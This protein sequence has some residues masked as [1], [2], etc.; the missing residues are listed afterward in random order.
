MRKKTCFWVIVCTVVWLLGGVQTPDALAKDYPTKPIQL[1]YPWPAGSGGDIATRLLAEAA[2]KVLGQPVKVI[3]VPG[4]NGTIGAAQ[5]VKAKK[6]G[7]EL[8]S[9]PI[10]P[11]VTQTVFSKDLPYTTADLEPICQFTYLPLVLVA[12]AHTPYK[13]LDE[14]V[15]YAKS[16]PEKVLFVIPGVGSVPHLSMLS[17]ETGFGIKMKGVPYKGLAPGVTALVGGHV[18]LAPASLA[19]VQSF[20]KAGKLRILAIFARKRLD[21]APDIITVEERGLKTYPNVWTG[22]FGPKGLSPAVLKV[23]E[24][25]FAKAVAEKDFAD[26]MLKAKQPVVFLDSKAFRAKIAADLEYFKKFA[27]EKKD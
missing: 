5:V 8:G 18:D 2:S 4:G 9:L 20:H 6:D 11:A 17:L 1:V 25:S 16:N 26:S 21:L 3:N 19:E 12:G 14:F 10:G 23:L 24:T 22:I 13:T 15:A 27:A 7:Y